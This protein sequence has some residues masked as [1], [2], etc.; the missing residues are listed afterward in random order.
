MRVTPSFCLRPIL[1]KKHN[2]PQNAY[3]TVHFKPRAA[4]LQPPLPKADGYSN[5]SSLLL[6]ALLARLLGAGGAL[7]RR[8]ERCPLDSGDAL[9]EACR[10][11][12]RERG[13]LGK[14][15]ICHPRFAQACFGVVVDGGAEAAREQPI[16]A[17]LARLALAACR[18]QAR[19]LR[20]LN[21]GLRWDGGGGQ[22]RTDRKRG[23][24]GA[25]P[26]SP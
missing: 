9:L 5:C 3:A 20:R 2:H 1:P 11:S 7:T 6:C 23:R 13:R 12:P 8:L 26:R 25:A 18:R 14:G 21:D 22:E 15:L 17:C 19:A 16:A 24:G 10:A 4:P